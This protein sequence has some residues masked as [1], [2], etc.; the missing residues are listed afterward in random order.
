MAKFKKAWKCPHSS[1]PHI[2]FGLCDSCYRKKRL[3]AQREWYHRKKKKMGLKAWRTYR[4]ALSVRGKYKL[5]WEAY[6]EI[7]KKQDFRC[8]CGMWFNRENG[9]SKT[10]HIDHDHSCCSGQSS[11][12]KCVRGAL[13]FRCNSVLGFLESE[14]HLLPQYLKAYL[15]K[16]PNH[17]L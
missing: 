12:G 14:P 17:R 11:C 2:A 16:Y 1:K 3:P 15:E 9:K 6:Q 13:C 4:H 5:T 10:A 7:L 8:I